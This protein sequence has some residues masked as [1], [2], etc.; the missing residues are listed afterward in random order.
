MMKEN[1]TAAFAEELYTQSNPDNRNIRRKV[2]DRYMRDML[3]R[4]PDPKAV[5]KKGMFVWI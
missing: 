2:V 1:L 3:Y 4:N 5:W